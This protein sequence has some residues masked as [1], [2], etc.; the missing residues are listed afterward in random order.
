MSRIE[1][2]GPN[3]ILYNRH[4][5]PGTVTREDS[6][7]Q[8]FTKAA[9]AVGTP[10]RL[11]EQ[12]EDARQSSSGKSLEIVVQVNDAFCSA[13][14]CQQNSEDGMECIGACPDKIRPE[15]VD[16]SRGLREIAG[17]SRQEQLT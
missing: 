6:I 9:Y 16:Q 1:E 11:F 5:C 14:P 8:T 10:H 17:Q 13:E 7:R 4:V 2:I 3:S 12:R 15:V